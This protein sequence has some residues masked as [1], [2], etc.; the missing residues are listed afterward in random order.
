MIA[1]L[2]A[3]LMVLVSFASDA[4]ETTYTMDPCGLR[5]YNADAGWQYVVMG[6]YPYDKEGTAQAIFDVISTYPLEQLNQKH[7][8]DIPR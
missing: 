1:L 4:E 7:F 6:V 2:T 8:Y 3:A 5:G